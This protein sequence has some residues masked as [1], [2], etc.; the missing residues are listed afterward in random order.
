MAQ[1][2][3]SLGARALFLSFAFAAPALGADEEFNGAAVGA[4]QEPGFNLNRDFSGSDQVDSVDP[5][6]GTMKIVVKDLFL[7][8]NGG[9]DIS[10]IRNYQSVTNTSGPYSN[11]HTAR[12][13]FGTGWDINFGRIWVSDNYDY[14]QPSSTNSG[15]QI[16]QVASNLNPILELPDG[17]REVL[18]NGD[19][20]DHAFISKGRWIG[21]CLPSSLN[22]GDGGLLV[23]SPDGMKYI[24]NVKGTLSPDY[25]FRTYFVSRI[26]DPEGNYLDFSYN[27][28][29]DNIYGRHHLLKSVRASDGRQVNFN[30]DD[31]T[32]FRPILS[33]IS[34]GG[35]TVSYNYIDADW[36]IGYE[37]HYLQSVRYSDGTSWSYT[38]NHNTSL[39]GEDPG[40]FSMISMK[41]PS[42]VKTSYKYAYRQMG[43]DP[44]EKSNVITRREITGVRGS[45]DSSRTW[46][47]QYTKGYSPNNDKTLVDGPDQCIRY[48]HIGSNTIPT[49]FGVDK[50]LWK[51]GLLLEKEIM[52][53]GCGSVERR[54]KMT[55]GSQNI[56]DQNEMRRYNLLVENY[57]R[58]PILTKKV[59]EQDGSTYTTDYNGH[60]EYGQPTKIVEDGQKDRATTLSYTR[61]GGRWMLGKVREKS[62]SGVVGDISNSYTSTG[63][64]SQ[65]SH[66]GVVTRYGYSGSGD[67]TSQTDDNERVTRYGDYYR[68]VPRHITYPDGATV[69]RTVNSRGTIASETDSLGR[70]TSYGYDDGDRLTSVTPPKGTASKLV[71]DYDIGSNGT[72]ETLV[73]G[74]YRR[75]RDYNQL[76]QLIGQ[77]E[78][79]GSAAIVVTAKYNPGGQRVFISHPAYGAAGGVGESFSY[80]LLGRVKSNTHADG[81]RVSMAYQSGNKV[82]IT[83]ERGNVTTQSYASYGE[84]GERVLTGIAQPGGV[85]TTLTVD[86]LGR[87]TAI[88]QGGLTRSFTF[89]AQGFLSSEVHPETGTTQYTHD[90]VGNVLSKKVG[91]APADSYSY[92]ARYR[93]TGVSYGGSGLSLSNSYDAGGRL[94]SQSHAGSTWS[95]AYDAHD[96]LIRETLS[97]AAPARTY[98]FNYAYNAFDALA[99]LTYPSGLVVDYAPDAYGRPSKAG[100]Y[101]SGLSYHPNG[102]LQTLTYGNGRVLNISQD[103]VR[104]RTSE[105]RVGGAATPMQLQYA[106]DGASNLTR[107]SDLQNSGFTQT[108]GYDALNRLISANGAWGGSTYGYNARGDLTSQNVGGRALNYAYD[109]QGRLSSISG[110]LAVGF[111]YDAKGNV[112]TGRGRYAYD[113]AGNMSYLCVGLRADCASTPDQRFAYDAR[114]RRTLQTLADGE[115]IITLYGQ[116]GQLLRQ[117]N[118]LDAGFEEFIFVAGERIARLERCESVDSDGDGMPNCYEKQA[119]F[120]RKDPADGAADADSDGLSNSQEY[121]LRTDPRN[122]DS[123]W[124]GM[125]DGWEVKYGLNPR[126]AS[127]GAADPDGDG[128]PN[129]V[130]YALGNLP[131]QADAPPKVRPD[132][133]PAL[134]L[135]LN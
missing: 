32:G 56:S 21:R 6:T 16:G 53:P 27:I 121:G 112:L 82:A 46:D 108:M 101:A 35:R 102:T 18:A 2:S 58:A 93:L 114:G 72:T 81:T 122:K 10:V 84:P 126:S 124:D 64:L 3:L 131:N 79:G 104:Q 50:G 128:V 103:P 96:K 44:R 43:T 94:T 48:E 118:L 87:V 111:G 39:A 28:P 130:E 134:D 57:T 60:D 119:G 99:S 14:L 85:Q 76:G 95:Y 83:D 115:Q 8:G 34:G 7:P 88:A 89:N 30:Y 127:D 36:G 97:L 19:G 135:L 12:T 73:R 26:E 123:D 109:A 9:L 42:G 31:E 29:K 91:S 98:S 113:L 129:A 78:S 15:C 47:Y 25:Q 120:D 11:G 90:A 80:D 20:S 107:I 67:L 63:K 23:Y 74:S 68:G 4:Y 38:Y 55:W 125:P 37:P 77:T 116:Q 66:Y 106:Y 92:D 132:L 61:P 45:T 51:I 33:S 49:A 52:S 22:E 133:S 13:P 41:S 70:T 105:R 24:F 117:D 59:I 5:F 65:V 69:S 100:A 71:I 110:G 54:E 86:N 17:S 62:V 1:H 40:R 75:V